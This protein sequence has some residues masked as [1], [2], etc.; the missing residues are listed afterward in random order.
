MKER[1]NRN[2]SLSAYKEKLKEEM[3]EKSFEWIK[4]WVEEAAA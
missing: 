2:R 3:R 1:E 4:E